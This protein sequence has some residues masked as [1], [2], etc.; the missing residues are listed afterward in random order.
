MA[1]Y[2]FRIKSDKKSDGSRVSASVHVDYI[3]RQGKY[4]NEGTDLNTESNLISFAGNKNFGDDS[5][6]LYLTD[7]FGKIYNTKKGLQ[8][9]GKYSPTTLA[10]AL[11]LAK[12]ISDNQPLILNGSKKIQ[13]H[14]FSRRSR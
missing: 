5:F 9:N 6:P 10:I 12:N 13:R 4:K 7:D 14:N 1:C 11:T 3:S 2:H 8:V